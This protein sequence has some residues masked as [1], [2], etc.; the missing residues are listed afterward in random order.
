MAD[1]VD[2]DEL[3]SHSHIRYI[4]V[5]DVSEGEII[6]RY[7]LEADLDDEAVKLQC[8]AVVEKHGAAEP[9]SGLDVRVMGG[10]QH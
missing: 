1:G 8:A 5:T 10:T 3:S 4:C 7:V 6:A 2:L 9:G